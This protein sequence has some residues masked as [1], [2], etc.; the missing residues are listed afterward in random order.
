[1]HKSGPPS[2]TR[3]LGFLTSDSKAPPSKIMQKDINGNEVEVLNPEYE[4]WEATD[5]QILSYLL[6][7]L[8]KEILTQVSSVTIAA[9]AWKEIQGMFASQTR[10]QTVNTRLSLGNTRKGDMSVA[11]YFGKMKAL[12]DEMKAAGRH[13][14]DE[15]LVEYII[16]G[17]DEEYTPLVSARC[18]RVEPISISELFSQLLNFETRVN[19][20]SDDHHR[21]ANSMGRGCGGT[22]G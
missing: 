12:G 19:L 13:L 5:Q 14:D 15:E 2:V 21:S 4:D 16:T 8:S 11:E 18:A 9:E 6:S 22:R 10:A 1:M 3:L 7:S 17:L 20:F